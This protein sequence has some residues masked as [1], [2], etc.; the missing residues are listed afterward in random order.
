MSGLCN[1]VAVSRPTSTNNKCQHRP[2]QPAARFCTTRACNPTGKPSHTA[3][4]CDLLAKTGPS[5]VG[6]A[7]RKQRRSAVF[8]CCGERGWGRALRFVVLSPCRQGASA[9]ALPRTSVG[10]TPGPS[11]HR[12][13]QGS[14]GCHALRPAAKEDV[15]LLLPHAGAPRLAAA[16]SSLIL[17]AA[18]RQPDTREHSGTTIPMQPM[19]PLPTQMRQSSQLSNRTRSEK[20][21]L[22]SVTRG[23]P[24]VSAESRNHKSEQSPAIG[25]AALS[26][27]S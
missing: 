21:S 6:G 18:E 26:E 9:L 19:A 17:S 13:C 15:I 4:V 8:L 1:A 2:S 25:T 22:S 12:D 23:P 16:A 24:V 10:V 7:G 3:L 27:V 11:G 14:R 20:V 5:A